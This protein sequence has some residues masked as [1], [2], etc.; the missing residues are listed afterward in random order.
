MPIEIIVAVISASSAI[1]G[2]VIGVLSGQSL[3]KYRI[4]K[5]EIEAQAIQNLAN[6]ILT[7]E[8]TVNELRKDLLKVEN[9]LDND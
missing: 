6:R 1:L 8:I 9:E 7:L 3:L 2:S 4:E 5:V